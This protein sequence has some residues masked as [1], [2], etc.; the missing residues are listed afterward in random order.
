MLKGCVVWRR[1]SPRGRAGG[2][3][4]GDVVRRLWRQL[5][6][7]EAASPGGLSQP[8]IAQ[9]IYSVA[10]S[11]SRMDFGTLKWPSLG[12]KERSASPATEPE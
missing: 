8:S 10:I 7:T 12:S 4:F 1:S 6:A 11:G 5:E 2:R 3:T 9:F